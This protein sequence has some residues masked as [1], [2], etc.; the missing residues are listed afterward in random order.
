MKKILKY[1]PEKFTPVAVSGIALV[2]ITIAARGQIWLGSV[3]LSGTNSAQVLVNGQPQSNSTFMA[4]QQRTITAGNILTNTAYTLQ[5]GFQPYGQT[6]TNPSVFGTVQTN[7]NASLGF[8]NGG[9]WTYII[10]AQGYTAQ[11]VPWATLGISNNSF[12]SG[13]CTNPVSLY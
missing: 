11:V 5:Y 2:L 1:I 4:F 9:S 6:T 13:T 10:P 12:P 8:T 7:L 3:N